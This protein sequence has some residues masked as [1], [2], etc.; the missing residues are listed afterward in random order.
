MILSS[1]TVCEGHRLRHEIVK[2]ISNLNVDLFGHIYNPISMGDDSDN[3]QSLTNE[4]ILAL[5]NYH[6]SIIIENCKEDYY[7][8]EKLLDS[9]LT[10]TIPIY[11]G[12]PS[13]HKFFNI[14]GFYIF[15]NVEELLTILSNI[16][17]ELYISKLGVIE[18][19]F[20]EAKKYVDF[21]L[22]EKEILNLCEK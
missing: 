8:D 18:E 13:I 20:N 1:K 7:F 21:K 6:F 4:K 22:N 9:L 12:C 19:N 16:T 5:K 10:G 11:W 3:P 17:P 2:H 14:D 15:N